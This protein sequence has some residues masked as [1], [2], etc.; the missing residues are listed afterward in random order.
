MLAF[1]KI[2]KSSYYRW[3]NKPDDKAEYE[4]IERIKA[5]CNKHKRRYGYR[6]VTEVLRAEY[7]LN[8]NH[9]R[10]S[11]IMTENNL[12]ARIRRK[13]FVHFKSC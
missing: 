2:P 8:V 1:L 5:I 9:K 11:R 12:Q 6:R 10:V 3:K 13:K 4:L 7:Q